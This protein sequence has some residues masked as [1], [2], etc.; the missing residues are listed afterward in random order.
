MLESPSQIRFPGG[1]TFSEVQ[2][3]ITAELDGLI[4][5]WQ[6]PADSKKKPDQVI[7]VVAHADIIR[8]ALAYY[9]NMALDD[10]LRLW[11]APA[12]LS[13][14]QHDGSG[15][16]RVININQAAYFTWPEPKQPKT[17][18]KRS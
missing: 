11:V 4:D 5:E 18:R 6:H 12:S 9:L 17:H 7:A 10:Y 13:V 2:Q 8:L 3:R 15:R 14:I 16:P 1:E